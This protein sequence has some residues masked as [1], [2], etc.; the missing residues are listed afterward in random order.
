MTIESMAV[1]VATAEHVALRGQMTFQIDRANRLATF[2][3]AAAVA[4]LAF[5]S[6]QPRSVHDSALAYLLVTL[7][8]ATVALAYVGVV[9]EQIQIARYLRVQAIWIRSQL[10]ELPDATYSPLLP[11]L[12]APPV[13][14]WEEFMNRRTRG[15]RWL[16]VTSS[17]AIL[18]L[19][20]TAGFG[21]VMF[22]VALATLFNTT[23]MTPELAGLVIVDLVAVAAVVVAI[24]TLVA[25]QRREALREV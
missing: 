11:D 19:A 4:V 3:V 2:G 20:G 18:E 15:P 17:L 14:A 10:G 6:Q 13:L 8:L 25:M 7:E 24:I 21:I 12:G 1:E 5:L 22:V 16:T 9:G 23:A